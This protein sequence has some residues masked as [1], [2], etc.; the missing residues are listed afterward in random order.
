MCKRAHHRIKVGA[1]V[2][3]RTIKTAQTL[4]FDS[5]DTGWNP[6]IKCWHPNALMENQRVG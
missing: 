5:S 1:H 3:G 2:H 4:P 6:Q